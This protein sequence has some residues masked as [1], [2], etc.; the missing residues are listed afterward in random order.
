MT[1]CKRMSADLWN[2]TRIEDRR[3]LNEWAVD[4]LQLAKNQRDNRVM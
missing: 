1:A 3:V 2:R 4:D